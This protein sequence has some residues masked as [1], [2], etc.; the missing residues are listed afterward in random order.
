MGIESIIILMLMMFI[1]GLVVGMIL[2]RPS[3]VH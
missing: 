3:H 1:L 2:A